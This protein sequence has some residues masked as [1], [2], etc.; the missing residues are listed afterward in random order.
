PVQAVSPSVMKSDHEYELG[1]CLTS[2]KL[3]IAA[4]VHS[5]RTGKYER[6]HRSGK[7]LSFS[8][9][10]FTA[11]DS[12]IVFVCLTIGSCG[13]CH[14]SPLK[15]AKAAENPRKRDALPRGFREQ[16]FHI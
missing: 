2:Q 10:E 4:N 7:R 13:G 16:V 14:S 1:S 11:S 12:T 5:S 9:T 15:E 8:M 3:F 6:P